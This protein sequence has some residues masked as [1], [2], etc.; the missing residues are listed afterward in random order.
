MAGRGLVRLSASRGFSATLAALEQAIAANGLTLFARFDHET[1]AAGVSLSLRP[2]T[3][4]VFG[5]ATGGTRLMQADQDVGIEL[6]LRML[7]AQ[8]ETGAVHLIHDDPRNLLARY[9]L[10]DAA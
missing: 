6:P 4:L 8:D 5:N 1:N 3:V 7:V 10:G 2:T 9:D